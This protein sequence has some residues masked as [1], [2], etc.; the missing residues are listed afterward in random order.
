MFQVL[1]SRKLFMTV[2]TAG[3][4]NPPSPAPPA[5]FDVASSVLLTRPQPQPQL[6]SQSQST[7][8][9][10]QPH[11][12]LVGAADAGLAQNIVLEPVVDPPAVAAAPPISTTA[13]ESSSPSSPSSSSAAAAAVAKL[14][15]QSLQSR[16]VAVT[17]PLISTANTTTTTSNNLNNNASSSLDLIQ[18]HSEMLDAFITDSPESSMKHS[19]LKRNQ[20]GSATSS[21][22]ASPSAAAAAAT[23]TTG[24]SSSKSKSAAA[25]AT[26]DDSS[27]GSAL[28]AVD[29]NNSIASANEYR[30][31][32]SGGGGH[33]VD[34]SGG[35]GSGVFSL[36]PAPGSAPPS[37]PSSATSSKPPKRQKSEKE[38]LVGTP[39]K[40]GHVN[41]MLMYDMLTGIRIS[42]RRRCIKVQIEKVVFELLTYILGFKM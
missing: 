19:H 29:E 3:M 31:S 18:Q 27:I 15:Q 7:E 1:Q 41:Y 10:I 23:T 34:K 40:E 20:S 22:A 26:E 35:S 36:V 2:T 39:V 38:V 37:A 5:A 4:N 33:P 28:D 30:H 12:G 6:Q 11:K 9:I 42:V 14:E 32:G 8:P 24:K 17:P 13:S 25:G 21:S 16:R